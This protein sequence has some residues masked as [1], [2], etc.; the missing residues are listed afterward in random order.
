[1]SLHL[2]RD[3]PAGEPLRSVPERSNWDVVDPSLLSGPI[4]SIV[5]MPEESTAFGSHSQ[6]ITERSLVSL[7]SLG[8][9][10]AS[11]ALPY[12]HARRR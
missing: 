12:P 11:V 7:V 2:V 1:M 3:L 8:A 4:S 9:G 6:G 5:R 10:A